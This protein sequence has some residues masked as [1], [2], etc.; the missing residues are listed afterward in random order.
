MTVI[1]R[2]SKLGPLAVSRVHLN[3]TSTPNLNFLPGTGLWKCMDICDH[4]D[5]SGTNTIRNTDDFKIKGAA[6]RAKSSG[7]QKEA[8]EHC[9]ICLQPITDRAVAV[10]CNHLSFDFICLV[11]WLQ[12]RETCPLCAQTIT[13]VQYNWHDVDDYQVYRLERPRPQQE[14]RRGNL[15]R[16]HNPIQSSTQTH[17]RSAYSDEPDSFRQEDPALAQRRTVYRERLYSLHVGANSISRYRDFTSQDFANSASFQS[18]ARMFLRRELKLF[19]HLDADG[20]VRNREFVLEYILAVLK[21]FDVK[22]ADGRAEDLLTEFLER[23]NARLLLH[24]LHSW[25]R[26]PYTTLGSW[27]RTVQYPRDIATVRLTKDDRTG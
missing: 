11:S 13:E 20:G 5:T 23:G 2:S 19:S 12:H 6:E 3:L 7:K 22:A 14:E 1:H 4:P 16:H 10:P 27:D 21:Q 9:I 8:P 17:G 26:S 25:L 15:Q 18:R 24:E